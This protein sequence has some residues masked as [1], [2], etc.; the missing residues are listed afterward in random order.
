MFFVLLVVLLAAAYAQ[1]IKVNVDWKDFLSKQDM[2]WK[3]TASDEGSL[4]KKWYDA[5]FAG[6][7]NLGIMTFFENYEGKQ[8]L[9]INV[10]RADVWD[11]RM[12]DSQYAV[13]N[14]YI[15]YSK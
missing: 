2:I 3:F 6:N 8:T 9:R 4:V 11:H 1:T 13:H 15:P 12:N 14:K 7:G 5:P 10:G